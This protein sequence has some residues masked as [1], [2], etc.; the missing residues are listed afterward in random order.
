[1]TLNF[2]ETICDFAE[3]SKNLIK[4]DEPLMTWYF[5]LLLV[6][7]FIFVTFVPLRAIIYVYCKLL[8]LS[9]Q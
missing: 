5:F 4:W 9:S 6:M 1:V 7:L 3:K 2:L 8:K